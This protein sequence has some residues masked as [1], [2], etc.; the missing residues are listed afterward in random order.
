MR[1]VE[2]GV[3]KVGTK[4]FGMGLRLVGK[5]AVEMDF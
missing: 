3:M 1:A 4:V 2:M 5:K